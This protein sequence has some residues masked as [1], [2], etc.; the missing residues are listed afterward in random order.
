M[1]SRDRVAPAWYLIQGNHPAARWFNLLHWPYLCFHLSYIPIGAALAGGV[2][3]VVFGWL[4]V[5]FF[6]GMGVGSHCFDLLKGDPLRLGI[7]PVY[8]KACGSGSLLL[9]A[10]IGGQLFV[11]GHVGA[12][13]LLAVPLG[14]VFA[15]GYGMEWPGLHGD[16]QFAAWWGVFPFLVSY[17]AQGVEWSWALIPVGVFVYATAAAQRVLST[18]ARFM[19]RKV[20]QLTGQYVAEDGS[21]AEITREWVIFPAERALALLSLAMVMLAAGLMAYAYGGS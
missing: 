18:Q 6:L 20:A 10:L 12:W 5:A 4:V 2:N 17:F 13:F 1:L 9:A 15:V 3:Y 11:F 8:L 19:R 7:K 21:G 14:V 16:W